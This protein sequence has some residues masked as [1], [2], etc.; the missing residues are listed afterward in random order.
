MTLVESKKGETMNE[1]RWGA[2][3]PEQQKALTAYD[4]YN[5]TLLAK[6]THM[7]AEGGLRIGCLLLALGS[8]L[9]EGNILPAEEW[10]KVMNEV[11]Q[12]EKLDEN[13]YQITQEQWQRLLFELQKRMREAEGIL[14]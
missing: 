9:V 4:E 6:V 5:A 10:E 12:A 1:S 2:F 8:I 3:T 13:L 7:L 11:W 14:G